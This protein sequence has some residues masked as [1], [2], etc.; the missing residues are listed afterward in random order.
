MEKHFKVYVY[1]EGEPPV[2]HYGLSKGILGLEGI[3]IHSMEMSQFRTR[4]PKKAHVFFLPFSVIS[5]THY[6]FVVD[7]HAWDPMKN[8]VRDYVNV[9]Q[10]KHSFWNRSR[11][12][13]HFMLACHDWVS[14]S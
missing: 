1:E 11:G 3:F 2:F 10:R 14:S 8:T 12:A 5:L 13:D 7:S 4:D 9:I 6:V